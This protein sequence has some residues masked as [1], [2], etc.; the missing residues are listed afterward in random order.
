[1][2]IISDVYWLRLVWFGL[3]YLNLALQWLHIVYNFIKHKCFTCHLQQTNKQTNK[4]TIHNQISKGMNSK[5]TQF[6]AFWFSLS[7]YQHTHLIATWDKI[8]EKFHSFT[9][10]LPPD[11][12]QNRFTQC[13]NK[14]PQGSFR[15]RKMADSY[16]FCKTVTVSGLTSSC[17]D[18][19]IILWRLWG[20]WVTLVLFVVICITSYPFGLFLCLHLALFI[21]L[22]FVSF[23]ALCIWIFTGFSSLK[24]KTLWG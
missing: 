3:V 2:A 14:G 11:L 6:F 12:F 21:A 5:P 10:F 19:N 13:Q 22:T 8:L 1:V 18:M 17:S 15:E 23:A 16:S 20:F 9:D 4:Q 7:S 24:L